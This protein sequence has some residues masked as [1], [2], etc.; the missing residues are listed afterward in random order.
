MAYIVRIS[1]SFHK[2]ERRPQICRETIKEIED[3]QDQLNK[4]N[5][6]AAKQKYRSGFSRNKGF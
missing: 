3:V 1:I 2:V 5:G 4:T 6:S